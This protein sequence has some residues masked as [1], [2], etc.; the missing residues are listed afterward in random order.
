MY[1]PG[2]G[3]LGGE[4]RHWSM[5]GWGAAVPHPPPPWVSEATS[6]SPGASS[7]SWG[8]SSPP[9]PL[10]LTLLTSHNL[11]LKS[12]HLGKPCGEGQCKPR[13]KPSNTGHLLSR[14]LPRPGPPPGVV[15]LASLLSPT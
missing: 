2:A 8:L 13:P 14:P 12:A 11:H 15:R 4:G 3:G 10:P 6:P 1:S 9:T 5:G 7:S